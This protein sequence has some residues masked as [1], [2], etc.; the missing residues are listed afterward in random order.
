[1]VMKSVKLYGSP[2]YVTVSRGP[3]EFAGAGEQPPKGPGVAAAW[4]IVGSA[5]KPVR[6]ARRERPKP[7]Q[8]PKPQ[9][10]SSALGG[11]S[12]QA[13]GFAGGL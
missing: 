6:V 9:L 13:S 3:G 2:A 12:S 10:E 5:A 1:M 11:S 7:S 8:Q 4:K